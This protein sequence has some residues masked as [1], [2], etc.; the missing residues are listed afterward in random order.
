MVMQGIDS[1]KR[2]F[3][4]GNKQV[5]RNGV[6]TRKLYLNLTGLIAITLFLS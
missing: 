1:G 5:G 4:V 3:A 2:P 6:I